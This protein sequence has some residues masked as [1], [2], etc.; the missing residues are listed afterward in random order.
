MDQ[1]D[2]NVRDESQEKKPEKGASL[3][4]Y[5]LLV[6]FIAI[7]CITGVTFLGESPFSKVL[8]NG[9]CPERVELL[10]LLYDETFSSFYLNRTPVLIDRHHY[11]FGRGD[12]PLSKAVFPP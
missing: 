5:V 8:E 2:C 11:Y 3:V 4:E 9:K 6:T 10:I 7:V 12:P 1:N